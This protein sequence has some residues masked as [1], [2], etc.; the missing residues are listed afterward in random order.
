[1]PFWFHSID[2]GHGVVT[3]GHK[4]PATLAQELEAVGLPEDLT[5]MSVLDIGGWDGWF[6]FE[7]ERRGAGRVAVLD[8]YMWAI[9]VPAQ[10]AYWRRCMDEGTTPLPYHETDLWHPDTMPGRRGFDVAREALDSKVEAIAVDFMTAD[11]AAIGVWD[12][13]LYLGVLYHIEDPMAALRRVGAVTG[14]R[15][16]IETEAVVVPGYEHEAL[17]RFSPA[18]SSTATCRT[19]GRRTW[20]PSSARWVP[21]ASAG[22]R[23]P[24]ARRPSC[25]S[26][27]AVPTTSG[28]SSTV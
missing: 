24:S 15:A 6:A 27:P 4:P 20:P 22:R 19:G 11:L 1:V 28:R 5:G 16:V 2:L 23:S 26:S 14:R 10:Q 21:R 13:V 18:P 3:N 9:D 8:H 12:L 7:A 17:W 25:W